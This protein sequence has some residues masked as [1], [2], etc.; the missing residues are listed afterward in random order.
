MNNTEY[1]LAENLQCGLRYLKRENEDNK[2]YYSFYQP[3]NK[4]WYLLF[5]GEVPIL[6][7]NHKYKIISEEE[8]DRYIFTENL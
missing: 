6:L 2:S 4:R 3:V 8:M 5:K 1:I 7:E